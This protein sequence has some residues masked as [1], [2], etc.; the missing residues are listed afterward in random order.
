[1]YTSIYIH[2]HIGKCLCLIEVF[3]IKRGTKDVLLPNEER[4]GDKTQ[5]IADTHIHTHA[6]RHLGLL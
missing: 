5:S 3:S 2:I 4:I 6:F 1:M